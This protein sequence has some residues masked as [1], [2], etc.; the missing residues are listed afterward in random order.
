LAE[1]YFN[2]AEA[3]IRKGLSIPQPALDG[4]N[5]I[6]SRAGVPIYTNSDLTLTELYNEKGREM[7]YEA[8]RRT[9]MIRF[10]TYTNARWDKSPSGSFRT[11][12]PIPQSSRNVNSNLTQNAGYP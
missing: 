7:A 8:V 3:S 10:G 6:R 9:D 12:Y 4:I 11:L 1:I 2:W 5:K